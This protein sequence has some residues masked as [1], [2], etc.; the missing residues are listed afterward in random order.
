MKPESAPPPG[1]AEGF[2]AL[3]MAFNL[4][5]PGGRAT[6][7]AAGI[8]IAGRLDAAAPPAAPPGAAALNFGAPAALGAFEG[9]DEPPPLFVMAFNLSFPGGR[10]AVFAGALPWCVIVPAAPCA[11]PLAGELPAPAAPV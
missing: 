10:T 6:L 5:F 9:A 8:F 4:S 3:F 2:A 11:P 7:G 1:V